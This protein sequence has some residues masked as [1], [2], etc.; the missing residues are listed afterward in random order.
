MAI[1]LEKAKSY[2][3]LLRIV[4]AIIIW[5]IIGVSIGDP[6][7]ELASQYWF[8][9]PSALLFDWF[10][11]LAIGDSDIAGWARGL[12]ELMFDPVHPWHYDYPTWLIISAGLIGA[13]L[14]ELIVYVSIFSI[15]LLIPVWAIW[16]VIGDVVIGLFQYVL[17]PIALVVLAVCALAWVA[18]FFVWWHQR[19]RAGQGKVPTVI[20]TVFCVLVVTFISHV[21]AMAYW[22]QYDQKQIQ[23]A[24]R[25]YDEQ[26]AA[27][28][29]ELIA[30]AAA[31]GTGEVAYLATLALAESER[32]D[33]IISV[34]KQVNEVGGPREVLF[35]YPIVNRLDKGYSSLSEQMVTLG[36]P[37]FTS[38][39]SKLETN[40]NL[41][42]QIADAILPAYEESTAQTTLCLLPLKASNLEIEE[43]LTE[44]K[45]S[46]FGFRSLLYL[47]RAFRNP[48]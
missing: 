12:F 4:P 33:E 25:I 24:L 5:G 13:L 9:K 11:P 34:A 41:V 40:R 2:P 22:N 31:S 15:I 20:F 36:L 43:M 17:F 37:G 6:E 14:A 3:F 47:C 30:M 27:A 46:D 8:L 35:S 39:V 29:D 19:Y 16:W 7:G 38:R 18:W 28:A 45:V 23:S 10:F 48:G 26:G 1:D 21:A 32:Y 42:S 44:E